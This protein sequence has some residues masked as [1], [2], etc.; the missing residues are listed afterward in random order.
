MMENTVTIE[1]VKAKLSCNHTVEVP[2]GQPV[3]AEVECEKCKPK[4]DGEQ[5]TRRIKRLIDTPAE[6]PANDPVTDLVEEAIE[7]PRTDEVP[8]G[9]EPGTPPAQ[10]IS[11]HGGDVTPAGQDGETFV[12]DPHL[13]QKEWKALAKWEKNGKQGERPSTANLDALNEQHAAG[14]K[15]K[16]AKKSSGTGSKG[17]APKHTDEQLY[18]LVVDAITNHGC[19]TAGGVDVHLY[20]SGNGSS[21]PRIKDMFGKAVDNGV[22]LPEKA[23]KSKSKKEG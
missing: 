21:W 19:R 20:K 6:A 2:A 17:R 14:T 10:V 5:P 4:K 18:D 8:E 15:P 7:G 23:S 16:Q 9:V 22:K 1:R 3:G 12:V 13:A 11:L